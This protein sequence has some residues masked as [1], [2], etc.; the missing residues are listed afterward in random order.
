MV[1]AVV[2]MNVKRSKINETAETL[3]GMKGISEVY[4]VGGRYDLIAVVRAASNDELAN[5]VTHHL[6][7]LDSIEKTETMIAFKAYS[8]HDLEKMFS[9]GF[10]K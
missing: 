5:L 3:S 6:L 10:S 4:S 8:R 7:N 2:L 9:I 1:T